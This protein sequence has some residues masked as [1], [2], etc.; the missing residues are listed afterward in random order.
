MLLI[1]GLGNIGK[2]YEMTRHNLGFLLAD[3]LVEKYGLEDWKPH[4]KFFGSLAPGQI[5]NQKV[6]F[7]KPD[8][9]MN[10]SGKSVLALRSFYK[11]PLENICILCDDLDLPFENIRF[12]EKGGSGGHNGLKSIAQVLGGNQFAR[13]KLGIS[14][15]QRAK[16][17]AAAFVL[18]KFSDEEQI[19]IPQI[20]DQSH[21]M[22]RERFLNLS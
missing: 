4:K 13:L 3:F 17:P 2:K 21:T 7:L 8:T 10:L 9:Y 15:P 12:K 14:N 6:I 1:V 11:I 20:L 22:L 5:R 19:T 18:Q 16:M